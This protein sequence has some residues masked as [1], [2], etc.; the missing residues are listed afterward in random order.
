V[1]LLDRG[2]FVI[3]DIY[4]RE[5]FIGNTLLSGTTVW[6]ADVGSSFVAV[7]YTGGTSVKNA[8][9][10]LRQEIAFTGSNTTSSASLSY[11]TIDQAYK[12]IYFCHAGQNEFNSTSNHT[13]N[14][15]RGF[16]KPEEADSLWVTEV[17]LYD[18]NDD[19]LAYAKLSEPVEKNKLETLTFK[20]ELEL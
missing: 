15:N 1:A 14:H 8:N 7:N 11:R 6:N 18:D 19:L 9:T 10:G 16:Y 13:Y 4:G 3:F 2:I 12:M 17:G 5:D 20:V